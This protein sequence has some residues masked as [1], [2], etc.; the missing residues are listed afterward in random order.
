MWL[1]NISLNSFVILFFVVG[2]LFLIIWY[3]LLSP[4]AHP[5]NVCRAELSSRYVMF[6]SMVWAIGEGVQ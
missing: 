5:F 3:I 4:G 1:L 6:S 2:E